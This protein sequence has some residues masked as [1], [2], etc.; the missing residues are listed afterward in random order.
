[1]ETLA[2]PSMGLANDLHGVM[3]RLTRRRS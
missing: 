2:D 1:M 3:F